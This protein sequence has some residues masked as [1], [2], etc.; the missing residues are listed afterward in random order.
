MLQC[1]KDINT[2]KYYSL[3]GD[4]QGHPRLNVNMPNKRAYISYYP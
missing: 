3:G 1:L 2:L 4:L